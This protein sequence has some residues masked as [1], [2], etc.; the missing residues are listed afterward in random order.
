MLMFFSSNYKIIATVSLS[1]ALLVAG[2]SE[3]KVTQ[4]QRLI[5]VVN[6]GTS[7]ID[8]NKG[9]QV[10]TSLQL[11]KD[12]QT[13]TKSIEELKLTDPKLQEFQNKFVKVFESLSQS[14]AKASQ[15]LNTVKTAE[16]SPSGR[17]KI[18]KARTEIDSA[19]TPAAKT[20]GKQSDIL[21]DQLNKYCSHSE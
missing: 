13:V 1:I 6:E 18:Q 5:Q 3:N 17:I 11:S 10:T 16:A 20:T 9:K 14:I 15:A 7:L 12:L 2:C 19:L 21:G 4:C 8:N